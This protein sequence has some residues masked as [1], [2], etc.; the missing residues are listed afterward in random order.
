MLAGEAPPETGATRA[1]APP[2]PPSEPPPANPVL[3][4]FGDYELLREIAHG[5][6]GAVY[7]ARQVSLNRQVAL[8]MILSGQL[9]TS[10]EVR[11]FRVEAEAAARLDHPNIVPI[12]EIGEWNGRHY[13]SMKLIEGGRLSDLMAGRPLAARRA[14]ALMVKIARA[15]HYAHQHGI[16]HRDLKPNNIMVDAQDEPHLTDFGLAKMA[17]KD[18]RLTQSATVLGTANYMAPEQALGETGKI[19][20][21]ADVYGLGAILYELVTARPPFQA[22]TMVDTLRQVVDRDP[23]APGALNPEVDRDLETICLKCLEKFPQHRYDSAEALALDL[24]RWLANEPIQARPITAWERALKW[25]RRKPAIAALLGL[26]AL[27]GLAGFAGVLWQWSRAEDA[28][29]GLKAKDRI[30]R[31]N[32]YVADMNL[33]QRALQENNLGRADQLI[34]KY[35]PGPGEEDLR[36]FEWRYLWKQARGDEQYTFDTGDYINALAFSPDGR[37][38]AAGG[39]GRNLWIWEAASRRLVKK[40][41]VGVAAVKDGSS[42]VVEWN[43]IQFSPDGKFLLARVESGLTVWETATWRELGRVSGLSLPVLFLPDGGTAVADGETKPV[44]LDTATWTVRRDRPERFADIGCPRACSSDGRFAVAASIPWGLLQLW[45]LP[46]AKKLHQFTLP[47]DKPNYWALS[48]DGRYLVAGNW[49]GRAKLWDCTAG[50]EVADWQ[51]HASPV[52]GLAFLPNS[53]TL[54]TAGHDQVIHF[55]DT[56]SQARRA[57]FKGHHDEVWAVACSPDGRRFASGGKDATVKLWP[58][59]QPREQTVLTNAIRPLFFS[60]DGRQLAAGKKDRT[61]GWWDVNTC[62]EVESVQLSDLS[63]P[64]YPVR[65]A[66]SADGEVMA[67]ANKQGQIKVRSLRGTPVTR[68][69]ETVDEPVIWLALSQDAWRLAYATRGEMRVWDW[70]K[71][72]RI[73]QFSDGF[74]GAPSLSPDGK[75]LAAVANGYSVKLWDIPNRKLIAELRAHKWVLC[76]LA[77]SP[78]SRLLLVTSYDANASLWNAADGT[79]VDLLRGHKEGIPCGAFSADGKTVATGSTDDTVKLWSVSTR[80][81]LFTL[82]G[83]G[84]DIDRVLFS[85]DGDTLAVSRQE[86]GADSPVQLFR[87]PSLA[88]I[89]E[90]YKAID[91]RR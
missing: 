91:M 42:G 78:D 71:G 83:F 80:Q 19:T 84:G 57:T 60:T 51:A 20:T 52:H 17:G 73:A 44:F 68:V 26:L 50:R 66:V 41:P 48:P 82:S 53:Q 63:L 47:P 25:A 30:Q 58:T 79:L 77:F 31:R 90:W 9:A 21:A 3:E 35:F 59:V 81:E 23:A 7:L 28:V 85:P 39:H 6:M 27:V 1:V 64:D 32:L 70:A 69:L 22:E 86:S 45:D 4:R 33:A 54:V 13:F 46:A 14:A 29:R 18:T 56:L 67:T 75:R 24:E 11:R 15:V 38:L 55:W 88:E 62:Q 72:E 8:K 61:V 65:E 87:A 76:A 89:D 40:L 10:A 16:L 74:M 5:G 43:K 36:G 37:L 2:N 49:G 12:Y 34:R